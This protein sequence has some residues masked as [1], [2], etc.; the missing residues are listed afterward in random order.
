MS[1]KLKSL[2]SDL[3]KVVNGLASDDDDEDELEI[4]FQ[5]NSCSYINCDEFNSMQSLKL[6]LIF[7]RSILMLLQSQNI[8]ANWET[9]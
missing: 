4:Q 2:L 7:L 8:L 5:S 1:D 9:Y 6:P 3:N